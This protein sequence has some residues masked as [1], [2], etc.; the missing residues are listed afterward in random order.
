MMKRQ[1][2]QCMQ[3]FV[4]DVLVIDMESSK[5]YFFLCKYWLG[6]ISGDEASDVSFLENKMALYD[7]R[8]LLEHNMLRLL[9]WLFDVL[10]F[11][12]KELLL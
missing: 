8:Y 9:F 2:Y 7:S 6:P 12:F 3:R 4:K 11:F 5:R 10:F 1:M